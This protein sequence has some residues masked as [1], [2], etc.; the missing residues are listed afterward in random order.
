MKHKALVL[1]LIVLACQSAYAGEDQRGQV[2]ALL[3]SY[4][5][6]LRAESRTAECNTLEA[7]IQAGDFVELK[8]LTPQEIEPI[9]R[10]PGCGKLLPVTFLSLHIDAEKLEGVEVEVRELFGTRVVSSGPD[11]VY[12]GDI[13]AEPGIELVAFGRNARC[14]NVDKQSECSD[15][16]IAA[17]Y[18][19]GCELVTYFQW[20]NYSKPT[21]ESTNFVRIINVGNSDYLV[22]AEILYGVRLSIGK[23]YPHK[24]FSRTSCRFV[25]GGDR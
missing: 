24:P 10:R 14:Y 16:I 22:H 11:D 19:S 23:L 7:K 9:L 17:A 8:P 20:F 15:P 21:D 4:W 5:L 12:A 6:S 25:Q 13:S 2:G 1:L 3:D 18:N